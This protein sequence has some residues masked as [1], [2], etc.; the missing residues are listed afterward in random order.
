[1]G[2]ASGPWRQIPHCFSPNLDTTLQKIKGKVWLRLDLG[3]IYRL[4]NTVLE[5]EENTGKYGRTAQCVD[6]TH[7]WLL[8]FPR[9]TMK[10][11]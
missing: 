4:V 6:A 2:G 5:F 7:T 3:V 8:S 10:T 11:I 1:M 9:I